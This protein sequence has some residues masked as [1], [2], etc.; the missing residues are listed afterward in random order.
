MAVFYKKWPKSIKNV[1][2]ILLFGQKKAKKPFFK[3]KKTP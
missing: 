3:I 1:S 2:K